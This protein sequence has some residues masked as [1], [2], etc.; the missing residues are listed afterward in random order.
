MT[1]LEKMTKAHCEVEWGPGS[2]DLVSRE[3]R[4]DLCMDMR[5]ALLALAQCKLPE[6]ATQIGVDAACDSDSGEDIQ[7]TDRAFRAMLRS[8]A[9]NG[10][11]DV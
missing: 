5:A 9:T 10:K 1:P 7:P 4:K 3:R 8:I 11:D 2:W 6:H